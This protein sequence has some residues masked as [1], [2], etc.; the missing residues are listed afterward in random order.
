[1][2]VFLTQLL[3]ATVF[4]TGAMLIVRKLTPK[5]EYYCKSKVFVWIA[6]AI[7]LRSL[8]VLPL[9]AF[10]GKGG[11]I[12]QGIVLILQSQR[13]EA[14]SATTQSPI[15]IISFGLIDFLFFAWLAVFLLLVF[16]RLKSM[17]TYYLELRA[18]RHIIAVPEILD[19]LSQAKDDMGV[20]DRVSLFSSTMTLTPLISGMW[21]A[22][23]VTIYIPEFFYKRYKKGRVTAHDFYLL[24]RHELA[25]YVAHDDLLAL[26]ISLAWYVHWFNPVFYKFT[27]QIRDKI[28]C[29]RDDMA[30][31]G[32][33]SEDADQM[34]RLLRIMMRK[35]INENGEQKDTWLSAIL[36]TGHSFSAVKDFKFRENN[37]Y[38]TRSPNSN[39]RFFV[40]SAILVAFTIVMNCSGLLD[41][42]LNPAS[43]NFSWKT[44]EASATIPGG[45]ISFAYP[46]Q[47]PTKILTPSTFERNSDF[48][49]N[50]LIFAANLGSDV[51][52]P[53]NGEIID[54]GY[55]D[56]TQMGNSIKIKSDKFIITIGHFSSSLV[57]VG[58]F[59]TQNQIIGKVDSSGRCPT[60]GSEILITDLN[61]NPINISMFV[62]GYAPI[63]IK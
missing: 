10:P 8:F 13:Q 21:S 61:G 56:D 35:S 26:L 39:F 24:F 62:D 18:P 3:I 52:S 14:V 29:A 1:M 40:I 30:M 38:D 7:Y 46:I 17:F 48:T 60:F 51:Y 42:M 2:E 9:P 55:L 5:L 12:I 50:R 45:E 11:R 49:V 15:Y 4:C 32:L 57:S 34:V 44:A 36:S 37:M 58:E 53:I 41:Q 59:V 23:Y 20:T 63:S 6:I 19:A 54:L 22:N 16:Y 25:H 43:W 47:N 28:E 27:E 33:S 31:E